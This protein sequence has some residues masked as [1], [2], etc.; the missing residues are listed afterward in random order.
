M[1]VKQAMEVVAEGIQGNERL[2]ER[3]VVGRRAKWDLQE[4]SCDTT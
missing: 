2:S 3:V 1:A 4:G